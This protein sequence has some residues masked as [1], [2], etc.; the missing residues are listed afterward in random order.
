MAVAGRIKQAAAWQR[1]A[2]NVPRQSG[3]SL[4]QML[5]D[6]RGSLAE[7]LKF[8]ARQRFR[9]GRIDSF[10]SLSE[11]LA[12][13]SAYIAQ[14]SLYG[15]LKT[16]MGTQF[17]VYF[18]DEEFSRV[19]HGSAV[20]LYASC[21]ADI[22]VYSVALIAERTQLPDDAARDLANR[23][24]QSALPQGVP[25]AGRARL[26]P[27]S[28]AQFRDRIA[29]TVW[30]SETNVTTA[31]RGSIDDLVRYAPVVDEFKA[32]DQKIVKNSIRFRWRDVRD[33][34]R[35]RLAAE[36]IAALEGRR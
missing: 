19:I 20:K 3:D 2:M 5:S 22:T 8:I 4:A 30:K 26:P 18:E 9:R 14:T 15:Y 13:R 33:Q 28:V 11:F 36:E 10:E 34:L 24:Y 31:F 1:E 23:L 27:D 32:L 25:E 6:L 35:T 17:R 16:R 21:L 12:T 29:K 7:T